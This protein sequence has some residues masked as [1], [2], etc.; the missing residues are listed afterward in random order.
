MNYSHTPNNYNQLLHTA[1]SGCRAGVAAH[2]CPLVSGGSRLVNS[3]RKR[4]TSSR[5][6]HCPLFSTSHECPQRWNT[7]PV[8]S[9]RPSKE[10]ASLV[11]S[12]E[13]PQ[14]RYNQ[15]FRQAKRRVTFLA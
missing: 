3:L 5:H 1:A 15:R 9:V 6:C 10:R 2:T 14:E 13:R 12:V 8:F 4:R 7:P 11:Q